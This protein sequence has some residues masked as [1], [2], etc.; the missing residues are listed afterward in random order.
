MK[1][2][3]GVYIKEN[4]PPPPGMT[5]DDY[6]ERMKNF[7]VLILPPPPKKKIQKFSPNQQI[8]PYAPH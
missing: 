7:H 2:T 8:K 4:Y 3:T 6:G 1:Y 5:F